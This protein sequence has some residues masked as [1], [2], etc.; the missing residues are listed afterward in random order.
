[1][2][3]VVVPPLGGGAVLVVVGGPLRAPGPDLGPEGPIWVL[4]GRLQRYLDAF[5]AG[6]RRSGLVRGR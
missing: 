6:K 3:M 1:V 4:A 2:L 5:Y